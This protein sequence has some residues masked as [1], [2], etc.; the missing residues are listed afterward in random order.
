MTDLLYPGDERAGNLFSD[1]ALV[2]A[3][4][5]VEQAWLDSLVGAGV[6]PPQAQA[7]LIG[8]VGDADTPDLSLDA[9]DGGNVVI[10]L[11][12]V[13]RGRVP[14]ECG[15]WLHRGLTSQDVLDT[16]LV[17]CLRATVA[18]VLGD[19]RAQVEALTRLAEEHRGSVQAG[20]TLGQHA[21][22]TTFGAVAAGWLRGVL[23][24]SD[25]LR[26]AAD[27][28][29]A[30]AAGA[31]GTSAAADLLAPGKSV[32]LT[33]DFAA[34]LGLLPDVAWH[35]RRRALTLVADGFVGCTDVWGKIAGDVV[36][37]SRPE[38][39][40]LAELRGGG[41]STMP[42]KSNPVLSTLIRRTAFG[43]PLAA[44]ELHLCAAHAE[45][46]RPAGAWQA[47]WPALRRL[48][49]GTAVAASLTA[50]LL[51]GLQVDVERMRQT[52]NAAAG[53]LLAEQHA[54]APLVGASPAT[55]PADY[56]GDID[57]IVDEALHR[58][59]DW[60]YDHDHT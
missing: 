54:L 60:M 50:E 11:L 46:E 35:T 17:L 3:L 58:A 53:D 33:T 42:H 56:L 6:A 15:R 29:G 45:D 37:R 44:A 21:V 57:H 13:L 41:S 24:A 16:A 14:D 51:A 43:A 48:G 23:D 49:R 40:E 18:Q 20:R 36:L 28:L 27:E 47:E 26:A 19:I 34:R 2:D 38:I 7:D 1:R 4:V 12:A 5:G 25:Y 10:P 55:D 8:L 30:Q 59:Q 32:A 52:A 9:E 31:A 22:P 39:A